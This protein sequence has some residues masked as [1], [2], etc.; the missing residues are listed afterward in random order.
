MGM[1]LQNPTSALEVAAGW[2]YAGVVGRRLLACAL[3][4]FKLQGHGADADG[5]IGLPRGGGSIPLAPSG[6]RHGG[7]P[8][9]GRPDPPGRRRRRARS[10]GSRHIGRLTV[11]FPRWKA[12]FVFVFKCRL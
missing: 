6:M 8:R 2:R 7:L 10:P 3:H 12:V 4:H 9:G 5:N 11:K 1:E